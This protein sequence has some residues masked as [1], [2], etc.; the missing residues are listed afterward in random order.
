ME[1]SIHPLQK[2]S[3]DLLFHLYEKSALPTTSAML[4]VINGYYPSINAILKT[5]D[6]YKDQKVVTEFLDNK[7][8]LI[9]DA[10]NSQ[11]QFTPSTS[12]PPPAPDHSTPE[13]GFKSLFLTDLPKPYEALK[14]LTIHEI[15]RA[16]AE[17]LGD[18]CN[19]SLKAD[20]TSIRKQEGVLCHDANITLSIKASK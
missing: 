8:Q 12:S 2:E 17:A 1:I 10:K 9:E 5:L 3:V 7:H 13:M 4:S 11:I 14:N 18:I 19:I 6:H 15:E 16:I 20:I